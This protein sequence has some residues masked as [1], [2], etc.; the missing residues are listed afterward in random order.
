MSGKKPH[1]IKVGAARTAKP[2]GRSTSQL[3]EIT[4][5]EEVSSLETKNF[6]DECT[7]CADLTAFD[8]L[9][10]RTGV[11][12]PRSGDKMPETSI[13]GGVEECVD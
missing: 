1:Q 11:E 10:N 8:R 9:P 6:V 7:K 3:V 5:D 4:V 13:R 12:V 2:A